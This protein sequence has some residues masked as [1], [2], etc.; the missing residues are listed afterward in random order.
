MSLESSGAHHREEEKDMPNPGTAGPERTLSESW[1][2]E[3]EERLP[4]EKPWDAMVH[5]AEEQ[6]LH[7]KE[8]D[9]GMW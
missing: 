3:V 9:G 2:K 6:A 7:P 8:D 5:E 1:V 4:H